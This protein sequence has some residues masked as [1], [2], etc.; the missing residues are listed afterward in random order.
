ME[1]M[2]SNPGPSTTISRQILHRRP[3]RNAPN[4][5]NIDTQACDC[6]RV[7]GS[8]EIGTSERPLS[9]ALIAVLGRGIS[10]LL[11]SRVSGATGMSN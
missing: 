10:A 2:G 3:N 6:R 5:S 7:S 11:F 1:T 8:V 9:T 4:V